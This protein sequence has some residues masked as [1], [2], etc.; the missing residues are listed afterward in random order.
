VAQPDAGVRDPIAAYHALLEDEHLAA[1]SAEVLAAGQRERKLAFGERPLCVAI[2]P[3]ILTRRRYDQAV[4]AA[5]GIYGAL[6][7]LEKALLKQFRGRFPPT[8][9]RQ[10]RSMLRAFAQWGKG[11]RPTIAIV[12]WQGLPTV[13][14]FEMFKAFFEEAGVRTIIFDPRLLEYRRGR[15]YAEG[16]PVNLVYRRVLTSEL[17]A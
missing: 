9:G 1:A 6:A 3:Q 2:R 7:T 12:D 16:K 13:P 17:I 11:A 5:Q 15:L 10:L 14:E 4:A 8:R